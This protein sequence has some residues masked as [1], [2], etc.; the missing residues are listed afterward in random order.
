MKRIL[1]IFLF[2]LIFEI[3]MGILSVFLNNS[4]SSLLIK[5][6]FA[7]FNTVM[8]LPLRLIDRTYPFYV[9]GSTYKGIALVFLNLLLQT[10]FVSFILNLINDKHFKKNKKKT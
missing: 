2:L 9:Q 10:I 1:K 8:A 3:I 5:W 7:F 4:N 6:F